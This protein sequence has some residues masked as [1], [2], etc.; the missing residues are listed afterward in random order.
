MGNK[1]LTVWFDGWFS[2]AFNIV[3]MIKKNPDKRPIKIIGSHWKEMGYRVLCDEW[4]TRP[5]FPENTTNSRYVKWAIDFCKKNKVDIFFPRRYFL[6]L[7]NG[8]SCKGTRVALPFNENTLEQLESKLKS[9][10]LMST[11]QDGEII[12]PCPP[13]WE[14]H[15]LDEIDEFKD[16]LK[17][18]KFQYDSLCM[19]PDMGTGGNGF[20]VLNLISDTTDILARLHNAEKAGEYY[21]LMPYLDGVEISVDCLNTKN[22]LIAI[23]RYKYDNTRIQEIRF[24]KEILDKVNRINEFLDLDI[25]YN[26]QFREHNKNIFLLEINARMSG[27]IHLSSL[28][29]ANIPY[30][31]IKQFLNEDFEIPELKECS[32]CNVERGIIV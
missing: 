13:M 6:D 8:F 5:D 19:K 7:A 28:A 24:E 25:P 16:Y 2:S 1:T 3:E 12:C 11:Y 30:L 26:I 15:N 22:G 21:V 31:A 29:G 18:I 32:V 9:H 27:G 4:I 14:F 23:P 17:D 20:K 10:A